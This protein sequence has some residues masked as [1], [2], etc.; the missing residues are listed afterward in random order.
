MIAVLVILGFVAVGII[1]G[2]IA[3]AAAP[4]GYQDE[5]GFHYAPKHAAR[6]KKLAPDVNSTRNRLTKAVT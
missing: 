3:T 6:R 2:F 4:A 1:V 5:S